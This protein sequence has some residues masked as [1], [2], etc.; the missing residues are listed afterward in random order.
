MAIED[1]A[2]PLAGEPVPDEQKGKD[3]EDAPVAPPGGKV[4]ADGGAKPSRPP[5]EDDE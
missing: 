1:A 3:P 2:Q 5:M 4:P